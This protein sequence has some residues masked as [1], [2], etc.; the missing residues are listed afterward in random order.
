MTCELR[1]NSLQPQSPLTHSAH[2]RFEKAERELAR[3]MAIGHSL[4][5]RQEVLEQAEEACAEVV[6]LIKARLLLFLHIA[7]VFETPAVEIA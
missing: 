6:N 4:K 7:L 3:A 1:A 5:R 2:H